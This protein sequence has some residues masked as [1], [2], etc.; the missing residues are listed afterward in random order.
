M[1]LY[2]L[3]VLDAVVLILL[4]NVYLFDTRRRARIY[5][6]VDHLEA[7]AR[8]G[9]PMTTG[10]RMTGQD[11]GGFLGTRLARVAHRLEEGASLGEAFASCP[12]GLPPFLRKMVALGERGGNLPAFLA[13]MR[14]SYRRVEGFPYR[15][16]AVV[17][18]PVVLTVMIGIVLIFL[19]TF[20]WPKYQ[21]IFDSLE[22][23][24]D[25][26]HWWPWLDGA[27]HLLLLLSV[28][29]A[30]VVFLGHSP[31]HFG[32]WPTRF[33]KRW[34]DRILLRLPLIGPIIRDHSVHTFAVATGLL[35]RAGAALPEAVRTAGEAEPNGILRGR[36]ERLAGHLDEG[37]KMADLCRPED[38]WPDDFLWFVEGAEATGAL[39]DHL[40]QAGTHYDTKV[41]YSN[42]LAS[43]TIVPVLVILNGGLVLAIFASTMLPIIR[44]QKRSIP[45]WSGPV[46]SGK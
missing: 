8:K 45:T 20:V 34:A 5:I 17:L 40:L 1:S 16:V 41:R 15:P 2:T 31:F 18:Y 37:G 10:L 43:R 25:L 27:A 23:R 24:L 28:L 42:Q 33:C 29:F 35:L 30:L 3:L 21:Y 11:L 22:I 9:L 6:L 36:Y 46:M 4:A 38:G 7:I 32:V 14:R 19:R 26:V 13:E 44:I 12:H 39:P